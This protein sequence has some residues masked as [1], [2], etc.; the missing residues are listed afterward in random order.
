MNSDIA[1][2]RTATLRGIVAVVAF[3]AMAFS[4]PATA[5]G[6]PTE[7]LEQTRSDA[8]QDRRRLVAD[9]LPL[10]PSEARQFWPLYDR[11]QHDMSDLLDKRMEIIAKL[12][13]HYDDMPDAM[14][15]QITID[16]LELQDARLKLIKSYLP[17]F[18]KVLSAK[19]LARYYQIEARIRAAVD[20]EIAERIPLI[21]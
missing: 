21:K 18:E 19:N 12:G 9:H 2:S 10:S 5:E 14:A 8:S 17:K 4:N 16:N 15:K 11:C 6:Q 1:Q 20:V 13:E 7:S 3:S